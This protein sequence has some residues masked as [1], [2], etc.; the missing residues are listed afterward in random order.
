MNSHK[1]ALLTPKGREAMVRAVVEAG[2]GVATV[3]RLYRRS[4]PCHELRLTRR[5]QP[6]YPWPPEQAQPGVSKPCRTTMLAHLSS[7][8]RLGNRHRDRVFV[9]IQADVNDMLLHDPSPM[10]E[11]RRRFVQRN[12][13]SPA[14]CE[15]GRPYLRRTSGLGRLPR[16]RIRRPAEPPPVDKSESRARNLA[17]Y[18]CWPSFIHPHHT[19]RHQKRGHFYF[20]GAGDISTLP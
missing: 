13:R 8:A 10:H 14:Y 20:V 19:L 17:L 9:H 12:P 6:P 15:T 7:L 5:S 2:L 3:A 4:K 16:P 1:N 18:A 11:V